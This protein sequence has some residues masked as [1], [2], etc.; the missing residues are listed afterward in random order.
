MMKTQSKFTLIELLV[1]I[2]II[3]I[4]SAMLLPVLNKA[5][6]TAK[7]AKCTSNLKQLGSFH[8]QYINDYNDF[9]V[10]HL[11]PEYAIGNNVWYQRMQRIYNKGQVLYGDPATTPQVAGKRN[12]VWFCPSEL[13]I[14][15]PESNYTM[16]YYVCADFAYNCNIKIGRLKKTSSTLWIADA[17]IPAGLTQISNMYSI[18]TWAFATGVPGVTKLGF[19]HNK[20]GNWLYFDGHVGSKKPSVSRDNE[21]LGR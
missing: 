2:A 7:T 12:T 6:E 5:R 11:F 13:N 14:I 4:L 18:T 17:A 16:N 19:Q 1:V 9:I 15:V 10:K 21:L 8:A 20:T 3:A